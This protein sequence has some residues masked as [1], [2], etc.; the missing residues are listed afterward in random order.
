[1]Q[2]VAAARSKGEIDSKRVRMKNEPTRA[3][4]NARKMLRIRLMLHTSL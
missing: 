1:M 2:S 4:Q 3:K